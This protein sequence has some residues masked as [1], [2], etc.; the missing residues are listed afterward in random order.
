MVP[1]SAGGA[2]MNGIDLDLT[3]DQR[4]TRTD[5]A[6]GTDTARPARLERA[7]TARD[8]P[9]AKEETK[10]I[11]MA[12]EVGKGEGCVWRGGGRCQRANEIAGR[13]GT[14]TEWSCDQWTRQERCNAVGWAAACESSRIRGAAE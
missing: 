7:R 2:S 10:P 8:A 6:G 14:G 4:A 13:R 12:I 1:S 5:A 9:L 3:M 11:M